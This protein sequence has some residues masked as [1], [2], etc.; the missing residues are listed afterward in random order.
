MYWYQYLAL[1]SLLVCLASSLVHVFRLIRLGKP[2][3]FAPPS[4]KTW[5]AI[6]YS[7][8]GAMSPT[9][10]E[11]AFLHLP[12]YAA[13]ILYHL[14]TFLAIFLFF[15]MLLQ[16]PFSGMFAVLLSVFFLITG[17]CGLAILI[18]RMVKHELRSLSSPDDYISNLLVTLFQLTT[19]LVLLMPESGA[20]YFILASLLLLYF[21]VGKLKHAI[22]FFAAR[23][24][25][26][27]FYGRRGVWPPK[28]M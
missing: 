7:F 27:L 14:G 21:P 10:K 28:T 8:T 17:G 12:T 22:Y 5:P 15:L 9:K 19:A 25:L 11:S 26:G 16:F 4:G 20:G 23:Y 2:S 3:D 24:Q 13:G 6:Q 1:A 18:K